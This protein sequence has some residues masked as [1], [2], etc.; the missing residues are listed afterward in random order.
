MTPRQL[1]GAVMRRLGYTVVPNWQIRH[2]AQGEY[3]K[4]LF[5]HLRID[6]VFDVGANQ[7]QYGTFLRQHIGYRGQIV[8][9][10]PNRDC[11]HA[12]EMKAKADGRWRVEPYA[13]GRVEG[14]AAF[15]VMAG[16]QFSSFLTPDHSRVNTFSNKNR[17]V[18]ELDVEVRTLDRVAPDI[19]ST[20]K[21]V[22]PY[23]KLDTQGFDLEVVAG[24]ASVIDRFCALQTEASVVPIYQGA[25]DM[26]ESIHRFQSLGFE[27]SGIF[28]N[29]PQH[30]PRAIE[31][32]CHLVN[33][34]VLA[35]SIG[36]P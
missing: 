36:G 7:G 17:V 34:R 21:S 35:G 24:G 14:T 28:P 5:A 6:C 3:L 2:F 32:D 33:H 20:M 19:L 25:A 26:A 22:A 10:E 15:N 30:F 29:N 9:F 23:L 31:F 4:A 8:S 16:S 11:L 13:L 1:A 27:L 18:E 12:L